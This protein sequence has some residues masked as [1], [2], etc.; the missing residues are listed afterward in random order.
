MMN[1]AFI[2]ITRACCP[3]PL[4][5]S[6]YFYLFLS[7]SRCVCFEKVSL[8]E[9]TRFNL[10]TDFNLQHEIEYLRSPICCSSRKCQNEPYI[11]ERNQLWY[12][13]EIFLFDARKFNC[14]KKIWILWIG[15]GRR[16]QINYT[17]FLLKCTFL[18]RF[19]MKMYN[20]PTIF[21]VLCNKTPYKKIIRKVVE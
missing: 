18:C 19:E 4:L 16:K 5:V 1:W 20:S 6:W 12:V 7:I 15:H 14:L 3:Y 2:C 10:Y 11:N 8:F 21:H 17:Q 9:I 13:K